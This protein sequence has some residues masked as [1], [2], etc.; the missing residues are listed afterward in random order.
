MMWGGRLYSIEPGV[1]VRVRGQNLAVVDKYWVDKL[2]CALCSHLV[3]ADVPAHV[4]NEKYDV[5]FKAILAL[6]KYYVAIP[7][8][9]QAYFQSLLGVPLPAS[10][11]WKLIEEVGGAALLIFPSLERM[12]A[13]GDVIHNDDSHVK[14]TDRCSINVCFNKINRGIHIKIVLHLVAIDS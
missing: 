6:Q 14:I 5:A 1:L 10:T 13:N 8:Y 9:R 7:F 12:A 2:R 3:I 11:Q 4:G